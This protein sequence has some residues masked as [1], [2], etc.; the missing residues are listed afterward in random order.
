LQDFLIAERWQLRNRAQQSGLVASIHRV[1]LPELGSTIALTAKPLITIG[2]TCHNAADTITRAINS[3]LWQDWPSF[4][5]LIADDCSNDDSL[6]K[7]EQAAH[8]DARVRPIRHGQNR[9]VAAARNTIVT[10]ARGLFIAFF[11]DDDESVPYR[12]SAQWERIVQYERRTGAHLVFCYSNR[13]VIE[14]GQASPS[15]QSLGIGSAGPEPH[16]Q[17]VAD[18]ILAITPDRSL[19]PGQFGSCT[20]MARREAFL[21]IGPFDEA[22]RRCAEIDM[23]I[24]GAFLGA[25]FIGVNRPLITQYKT[26]AP[27]KAGTKPLEYALRLRTKHRNYLESRR[28]Y[29]ASRALA[30]SDFFGQRGQ[31]WKSRAYRLFSLMLGPSLLRAEL[32]RRLGP[33]R[34]VPPRREDV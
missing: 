31:I 11:D 19:V 16:G 24:R 1:S 6:S 4:E 15:H 17:I 30:Y 32:K 3:A 12:L 5:V 14:H 20:L 7:I 18:H 29:F 28:L 25:H 21:A 27:D 9:G 34:E 8:L 10:N 26:Q 23:A 13:N 33:N 22:F 2:I